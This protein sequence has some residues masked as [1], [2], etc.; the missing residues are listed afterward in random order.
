[1]S[2]SVTLE[3]LNFTLADLLTHMLATKECLD[4]SELNYVIFTVISV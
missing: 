4:E 3:Y 1:M 2:Y